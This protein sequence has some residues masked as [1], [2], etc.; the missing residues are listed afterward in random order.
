[1]ANFFNKDKTQLKEDIIFVVDTFA[2]QSKKGNDFYTIHFLS[3]NRAGDK[4]FLSNKF[5]DKSVFDSVLY[6]GYYRVKTGGIHGDWV[7]LTPIK[8]VEI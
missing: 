5:V 8:A 4:C 2:G 1:M 3:L 7:A 6:F